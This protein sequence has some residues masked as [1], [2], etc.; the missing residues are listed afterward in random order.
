MPNH[1]ISI[2][3]VNYFE[4]ATSLE[5]MNQLG[6]VSE[7]LWPSPNI[8]TVTTHEYYH[9]VLSSTTLNF[10]RLFS[11]TKNQRNNIM[12]SKFQFPN[13]HAM[14]KNNFIHSSM[15][16]LPASKTKENLI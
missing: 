12:S 4:K 15:K 3:K 9:F 13:Y 6:D 14:T 16:T 8:Q 10:L 7:L 2:H 1:S 11:M 5:L